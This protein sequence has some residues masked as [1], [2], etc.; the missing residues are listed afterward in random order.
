MRKLRVSGDPHSFMNCRAQGFSRLPLLVFLCLVFLIFA[1]ACL[2]AEPGAVKSVLVLQSFS[3][4]SGDFVTQL[5]PEL[6]ARIASPVDFYVESL[7]TQR[8]KQSGYLRNLAE[9]IRT[10]Y[11]GCKLDLVIVVNFPALEFAATYRERMFPGVPIV[12]MVVDA[13]RIKG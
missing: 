10:S 13:N 8:F 3:G 2:A 5:K 9:T 12:F 4:Y 7:E 1:G 6:R 11:A